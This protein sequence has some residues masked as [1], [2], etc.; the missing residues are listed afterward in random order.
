MPSL[1]AP[2]ERTTS[3]L[4]LN[5]N[6]FPNRCSLTP[7]ASPSLPIRTLEAVANVRTSIWA[8]PSRGSTKDLEGSAD[9]LLWCRNITLLVEIV[10]LVPV[11]PQPPPVF[12]RG[13]V[14]LVETP[15]LHLSVYV[16]RGDTKFS[17]E[18]QFAN[19]KL[20]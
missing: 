18:L 15:V 6:V 19:S 11:R 20:T 16:A 14:R 12:G 4:A 17:K 5:S 3:F 9:S 2:A 10:I 8:L 7:L 1:M 13:L